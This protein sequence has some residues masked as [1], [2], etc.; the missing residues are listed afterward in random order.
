MSALN[1]EDFVTRHILC[2]LGNFSGS[3]T[4]VVY[5]HAESCEHKDENVEPQDPQVVKIPPQDTAR[6]MWL[7]ATPPV[8][9]LTVSAAQYEELRALALKLADRAATVPALREVAKIATSL[10]DS[11]NAA[12]PELRSALHEARPSGQHASNERCR[13]H[14]PGFVCAACYLDKTEEK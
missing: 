6:D 7:L 3:A 13:R 4:R 2:S 12:L 1:P 11:T 8:G 5:K 10:V 9:Q 14:R